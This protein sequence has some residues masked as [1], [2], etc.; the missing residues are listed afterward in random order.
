MTRRL[1]HIFVFWLFGFSAIGQSYDS[2]FSSPE[3]LI[4]E[5]TLHQEINSLEYRFHLPNSSLLIDSLENRGLTFKKIGSD[6]YSSSYSDWSKLDSLQN[7]FSIGGVE[8][9]IYK[10]PADFQGVVSYLETLNSTG[11]FV[12]AS[13]APSSNENI[14]LEAV[15][16]NYQPRDDYKYWISSDWKFS[17]VLLTIFLF[18]VG[19]IGMILFLLILKSKRNREEELQKVYDELVVGPL[20]TLLFEKD[21]AQL[22]EISPEELQH[23]FPNAPFQKPLFRIVLINRII[24]LNKKMK[25]DFKDKLKHIYKKLNL[26]DDTNRLLKSKSWSDVTTGIVQVNEM[27]LLEFLLEV[28]KHTNSPNFQVRNQAGATLLNLSENVD[29]TFLKEQAYP[30]SDWQQMHYLR[31]IKYVQANKSLEI[32]VLFKSENQTVRCFGIK[33]VKILGR[34]DLLDELRE[35][36]KHARPDEIIE[37]LKTYGALGAHMEIDF[38][39]NCLKNPLPEIRDTAIKVTGDLGNEESIEILLEL[40]KSNPNIPLRKLILGSLF[41]LNREVFE[42]YILK[43]PQFENQSIRKELTDQVLQHV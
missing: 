11:D 27:D 12:L 5:L 43:Y 37:V 38:I 18:L 7:L 28:K 25:G 10:E 24:G 33:L 16:S 9:L 29:L 23:F 8:F 4:K 20:T 34:L 31:I 36:T 35:L 15:N 19:S 42:E 6:W 17:A 1:V 40:L 14:I 21:L 30:L 3:Q 26:T 22:E 32:S 41:R 13:A 39:N 2:L